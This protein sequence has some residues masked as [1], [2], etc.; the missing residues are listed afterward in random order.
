[1]NTPNSIRGNETGFTILEVIVAISILSIGLL[2]VASMQ[3]SSIRG[4]SLASGVTEGTS[5]GTDRMEKI[6]S[7][8]Y[9]DYDGTNLQDVDGDGDAGLDDATVA[10][11]DYSVTEGDY[12]IFWNI[13]QNSFLYDT[14]I[15]NLIVVWTE[16]RTEKRFAIRSLLPKGI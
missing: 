14:K 5:W 2:A 15:V 8:A 1:M 3:V 10:G 16:Q 11:A 12:D 7:M 6:I 13:A 4:N 9:I